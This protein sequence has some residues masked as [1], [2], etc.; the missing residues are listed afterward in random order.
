MVPRVRGNS[1]NDSSEEKLSGLTSRIQRGMERGI[2]PGIQARRRGGAFAHVFRTKNLDKVHRVLPIGV[3]SS[4]PVPS[5]LQSLSSILNFHHAMTGFL[6]LSWLDCVSRQ[7][8]SVVACTL[9]FVPRLR[10][11]QGVRVLRYDLHHPSLPVCEI[12]GT[13]WDRVRKAGSSSKRLISTE[14][15]CLEGV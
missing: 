15:V 11:G 8:Y 12:A 2:C 6:G 13:V 9:S 5:K 4:S 14:R 7:V 3:P 10:L 1:T